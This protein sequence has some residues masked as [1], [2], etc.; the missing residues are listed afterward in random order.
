VTGFD[1]LRPAALIWTLL[2]PAIAVCGWIALRARARALERCAA[3]RQRAR[4]LA[5]LAGGRPGTR[6]ALAVC[7]TFL[8]ALAL[9]GPV[10]GYTVRDVERRGLDLVIAFDTSRSMLAQDLRPDRL[11]RA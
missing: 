3:P 1:L 9:C 7:G 10:R 2:A 8:L 11:T 5:S 6:L 4:F